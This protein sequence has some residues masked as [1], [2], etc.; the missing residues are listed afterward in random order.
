MEANQ[1]QKPFEEQ[2]VLSRF[3]IGDSMNSADAVDFGST[4]ATAI[5]H[6]R[7]R[8]L[9]GRVVP[10]GWNIEDVPL[11]EEIAEDIFNA[12]QILQQQIMAPS[13]P[14]CLTSSIWMGLGLLRCLQ[15]VMRGYVHCFHVLE[16]YDRCLPRVHV[17]DCEFWSGVILTLTLVRLFLFLTYLER[18]GLL[19]SSF[20]IDSLANGLGRVGSFDLGRRI[21]ELKEQKAIN[22]V[23]ESNIERKLWWDLG[24]I[25]MLMSR[26]VF[27]GRTCESCGGIS[28]VVVVGIFSIQIIQAPVSVSQYIYFPDAMILKLFFLFVLLSSSSDQWAHVLSNPIAA[29]RFK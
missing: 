15:V 27:L 11:K 4:D 10:L 17:N 14:G 21:D 8:W 13:L 16:C 1:M 20:G 7:W 9:T 5:T 12:R 22:I 29:K 3:V 2:H 18:L 23:G 26:S 19:G 25:D 28:V 24:S 6:P